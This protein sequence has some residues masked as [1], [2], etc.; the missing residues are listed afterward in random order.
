MG[1]PDMLGTS[2]LSQG[3]WMGLGLL[4]Q[5]FQ[6]PGLNWGTP[7]TMWCL[8][9]EQP[10]AHATGRGRGREQGDVELKGEGYKKAGP[11]WTL[12]QPPLSA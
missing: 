10:E 11:W 12:T 8:N 9:L 4:G 7:T 3:P 2:P 6:Q 5:E 1:T